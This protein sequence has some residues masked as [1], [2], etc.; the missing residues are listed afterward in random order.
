MA[1]K[2]MVTIAIRLEENLHAR[3]VLVAK[4][5]D[6]TLTDLIRDA[7]HFEIQRATAVTE[8]YS[9]AKQY[10]ADLRSSAE[11][12]ERLLTEMFFDENETS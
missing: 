2:K 1:T 4:L 5:T 11:A 8:V 12:E 6:R 7:V 10:S 9:R 3:A